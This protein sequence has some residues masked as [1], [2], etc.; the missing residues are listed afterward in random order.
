MMLGGD[1]HRHSVHPAEELLEI[2]HGLTAV[3]VCHGSGTVWE[4]I[5]YRNQLCRIELRINSGV[6]GT[7]V[8]YAHHGDSG[9]VSHG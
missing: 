2:G 7:E 3:L 4:Q 8:A 6:D 1:R 9:S 5:A